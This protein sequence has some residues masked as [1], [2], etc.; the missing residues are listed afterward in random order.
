[1]RAAFLFLS[2]LAMA[3]SSTPASTPRDA[4]TGD[5]AAPSDAGADRTATS[6]A[7]LPS[8]CPSADLDFC[9]DFQSGAPAA[10]WTPKT[11]GAGT[12]SVTDAADPKAPQALYVKAVGGSAALSHPLV[13]TKFGVLVFFAKVATMTAE[14]TLARLD[15]R[16]GA[17]ED[18]VLG[19]FPGTNRVAVYLDDVPDAGPK[20]RTEV[21]N[22][23]LDRYARFEITLPPAGGAAQPL[24]LIVN[25]DLRAYSLPLP[26]PSP[27]PA[28]TLGVTAN[29]ADAV[30]WVDTVM[31]TNR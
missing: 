29:S 8:V 14:A 3:C 24:H 4:S 25:D 20:V 13:V 7:G 17:H 19:P 31:L 11:T 9:D 10:G 2:V 27:T 5:G 16:A 1:M 28:F 23:P 21:A 30:L 22:F 15:L 6:D 18:V 26:D 12:F